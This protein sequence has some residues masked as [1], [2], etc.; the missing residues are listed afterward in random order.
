[1][2]T[3]KSAKRAAALKTCILLHKAGELD[4]HL[5]PRKN[6]IP[7]Q[8]VS[9]LFTHYPKVKEEKAGGSRH[10]RLHEK[11]VSTIFFNTYNFNGYV[12]NF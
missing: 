12:L 1:M 5:L 2:K 3:I 8:D 4:D 9:F 11:R 10:R 7:D 6:E